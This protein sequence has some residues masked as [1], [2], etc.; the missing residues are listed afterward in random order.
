[1]EIPVIPMLAAVPF[2]PI[3]GACQA[4]LAGSVSKKVR[5]AAYNGLHRRYSRTR[6]KTKHC[7]RRKR[8]TSQH[9][10]TQRRIFGWRCRGKPRAL[11]RPPGF[12]MDSTSIE[13]IPAKFLGVSTAGL[14]V[15]CQQWAAV[16]FTFPAFCALNWH[17]KGGDRFRTSSRHH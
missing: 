3:D 5:L 14:P 16:L 8:Y 17:L 1:M 12:P 9:N 4:R 10:K 6:H 2:N 11:T 15:C 13:R 7:R